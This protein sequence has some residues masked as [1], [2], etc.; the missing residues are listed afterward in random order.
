MRKTIQLLAAATSI[1]SLGL[2]T[3]PANADNAII[4]INKK[5]D[6]SASAKIAYVA[7]WVTCSED[8]TSAEL[9][10]TLTQ[11]TSGGTQ[12]ATASVTSLSAFECSGEEELF[13]MPVRRPTGGF[14]WVKGKARV[15]DFHFTTADPSGVYTDTAKGR[16]VKLM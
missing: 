5:G 7:V 6:R 8:T 4:Q 1:A 2:M 10:A 15:T 11:V 13:L 9:V 12:T 14:K 16:T 3:V